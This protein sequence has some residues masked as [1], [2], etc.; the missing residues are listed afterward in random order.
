MAW[1]QL[2]YKLYCFKQW[3]SPLTEAC[4]TQFQWL[5][6]RYILIKMCKKWYHTEGLAADF[7]NF[8]KSITSTAKI[9]KSKSPPQGGYSKNFLKGVCG[10][11]FRTDTLAKEILVENIPLAKESFLIMSPFVHDFKELQPKYSLFKRNFRKTDAN[12]AQKCQ[13]LGIFIKD[14]PLAK[15]FGRKIYPWLRNFCQKYTLHIF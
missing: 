12:L 4:I 3:Y 5:W 9:F 7:Q 11:G 6:V 10:S 15:D 2:G 13:F 1:S 14:I 8:S